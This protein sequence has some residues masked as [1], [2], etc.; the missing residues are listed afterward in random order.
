MLHD[1][2]KTK[3]YSKYINNK[4]KESKH[5]TTKNYQCTK[6]E[7]INKTIKEPQSNQKAKMK[8]MSL[9]INNYSKC[10]WFKLSK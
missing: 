10:K 7:T 5:T 8:I 6:K 4:E 9:L 1:N 2:H 3:T